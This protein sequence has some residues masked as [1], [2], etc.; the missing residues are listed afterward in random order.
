MPTSNGQISGRDIRQDTLR[1]VH[2]KD[3]IVTTPKIDDLAVTFPD[4]IDDPIW[5]TA[6]TGGLFQNATI[7][8]T[9]TVFGETL[10]VDV[11]AWV[12]QVSIFAL[13]IFQLTNTSGGDVLMT[14]GV[15][16]AGEVQQGRSH[17]AVNNQTQVM[18]TARVA[19]LIGVAGSSIT[20]QMA[21][22]ISTGTNTT[23]NGGIYGMA[24][25]SR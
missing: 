9:L 6:I 2:M 5:S 25:G 23:N 18:S 11:P 20:V 12:D 13:G 14:A 3:L 7:T 17:E 1:T 22:Q 8:T 21:C 19:N 15:E 10:T 16:I 24:V 4:K